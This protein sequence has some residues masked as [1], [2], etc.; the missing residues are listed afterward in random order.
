MH[1]GEID[2]FCE[3]LHVRH[4]AHHTIEGSV[5]F[6]ANRVKTVL[7][8]LHN[9]PFLLAIPRGR[10]FHIPPQKASLARNLTEPRGVLRQ[11]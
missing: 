2:L 7:S 5:R 1:P 10:R 3:H 11:P 9:A 4:Y 6:R 8:S